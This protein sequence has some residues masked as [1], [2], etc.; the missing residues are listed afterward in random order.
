MKVIYEP[1]GKAQEYSELAANLYQG[2]SHGCLYCYAPKVVHQKKDEFHTN[3]KPRKDV[4]KWLDR[5][6]PHYKGK[7]VFLCFTC[8]PYGPEEME[9]CTT[10]DAIKLLYGHSVGVNI[11]TKGGDRAERDLHIL[12]ERPELSRLGA[13]LTF[14]NI[15]DSLK[16]EPM[17]AIPDSRIRMLYR[18]HNMGIKTWASMEPVIDPEQTLKLIRQTHQFVDSYKVGRWNHDARANDIDWRDFLRRVVDLLEEKGCNYYIKRDLS[19]YG[20]KE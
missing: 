15:Q 12:A 11:L 2:C 14:D 9:H 8:D 7:E 4:L 19:V 10:R 3:I 1:S 18:A 17:A 20:G 13:T 6:A 5:Q 16:W